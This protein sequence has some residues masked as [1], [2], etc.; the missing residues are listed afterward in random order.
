M[1]R[2]LPQAV[3]TNRWREVNPQITQISQIIE[4][5]EIL[6]SPYLF[7]LRNL[8][9]LRKTYALSSQSEPGPDALR[10]VVGEQAGAG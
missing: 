8:R 3:L 2:P 7:D 9:N 6:A 1:A 10:E 4:Q 5:S